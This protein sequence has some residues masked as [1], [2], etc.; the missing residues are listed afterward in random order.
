MTYIDDLCHPD[1]L[2]WAF[3]KA[4]RLFLMS[5]GE[6]DV[7]E[8]HSFE[9]N[10]TNELKSIRRDFLDGTY[11]TTPLIPAPIP[12]RQK[13]DEHDEE[14]QFLGR[15]FFKVSFRDQVAWL[16]VCSVIGPKL[17]HLMPSWSY[18]HRLHRAAWYEEAPNE[19]SKLVF[20][21]Y[22]HSNGQFYSKFS[23]GW[24]RYR[25]HLGIVT[26]LA[27]GTHDLDLEE[28][29]EVEIANDSK[30]H[31]LTRAFWGKTDGTAYY[32]GL[33][34]S[35]FYPSI[36]FASLVETL[37]KELGLT[38]R[39]KSFTKLLEQLSRF[40]VG[41]GHQLYAWEI[42]PEV[43]TKDGYL[44]GLPTGLYVSG[45]LSNVYMTEIDHWAE[46]ESRSLGIAHT[47]F[48]DDHT[49][50]GKDFS[51][52]SQYVLNYTRK[53]QK[54]GLSV[55]AEKFE[56][57]G[58]SLSKLLEAKTDPR[59]IQKCKL[60]ALG[61]NQSFMTATV[62]RISD[63]GRSDFS[64]LDEREFSR[65]VNDFLH[66]A[67]AD[68]SEQEI[69]RSTRKSFA[70]NKIS[71]I[72]GAHA[73]INIE[74][75]QKKVLRNKLNNTIRST[76]GEEKNELEAQIA[77]LDV[78][79][80]E[81]AKQ[82]DEKNRKLS[83]VVF[84]D[85]QTA[86]YETPEK[87]RLWELLLRYCLL[88]GHQGV[89]NIFQNANALEDKNLKK[90]IWRNLLLAFPRFLLLA[91]NILL[92]EEE[93]AWRQRRALQFLRA[94]GNFPFKKYVVPSDLSNIDRCL[95]GASLSAVYTALE[96]HL[97]P[98]DLLQKI[99]KLAIGKKDR[100]SS[101]DKE[102]ILRFI[103]SFFEGSNANVQQFIWVSTM[104]HLKLS[105]FRFESSLELDPRPPKEEELKKLANDERQSSTF[106]FE[107]AWALDNLP[108]SQFTDLKRVQT[109]KSGKYGYTLGHWLQDKIQAS[110]PSFSLLHCEWTCLAIAKQTLDLFL[111]QSYSF[112]NLHWSNLVIPK[113]WLQ[114]STDTKQN[115]EKWHQLVGENPVSLRSRGR[116]YE[117]DRLH[118]LFEPDERDGIQPLREVHLFGLFLYQLLVPNLC[119]PSSKILPGQERILG[120]RL[121]KDLELA[122][123]STETFDILR[124]AISNRGVETSY[125]KQND[126][127]SLFRL[128]ELK[129]EPR[130]RRDT[131]FEP[132]PI[133][134]LIGLKRKLKS[135]M[136]CL[137]DGQLSIAGSR[138]RQLTPIDLK[139]HLSIG[140]VDDQ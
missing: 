17:D 83:N 85:L 99:S 133:T 24:P 28:E 13:S 47:R 73:H 60:K 79:I 92:N 23:N 119:W 11:D 98:S 37:A 103:M 61:S 29:A 45:F 49:F 96:K 72:M 62:R 75:Q 20:G 74:L 130:F 116:I 41:T 78:E 80:L 52:L 70:I 27:T 90:Y 57:E 3:R 76:K 6:R 32:I 134:N 48:V 16:A 88:T 124:A 123:V 4:K 107:R 54:L 58:L 137:E 15:Q 46:T 140:Q 21:P 82:E 106:F 53:L 97:A 43:S 84:L 26:K 104:S 36:N 91:S 102:A 8:F 121:L 55:N 42:K 71:Q 120:W 126:L 87:F 19:K 101:E 66:L 51:D 67:N 129:M 112:S 109:I 117:E 118:R 69:R 89:G 77:S 39:D 59:I 128:D 30:F 65:T 33:D 10:L 105:S 110:L 40:T 127:T 9:L 115:W 68:I 111:K 63:L 34:L 125:M 135:A 2:L 35:T 138:P 81:L 131:E 122:P 25:R 12:K 5:E 38:R 50:I 1:T 44:T 108:R 31:Y 7:V 113:T 132:E 100:V 86:V 56:P 18:G 114:G 95:I 64:L 14:D 22:R 94:V 139:K 136:E 93:L